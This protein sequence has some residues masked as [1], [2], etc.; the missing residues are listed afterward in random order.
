MEHARMFSPRSFVAAQFGCEPDDFTIV[1]KPVDGYR[2]LEADYTGDRATVRVLVSK[3]RGALLRGAQ[4]T[5][6]GLHRRVLVTWPG[7]Q[8]ETQIGVDEDVAW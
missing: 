4:H 3:P 6:P 5:Q 7:G 8:A 1:R 2:G